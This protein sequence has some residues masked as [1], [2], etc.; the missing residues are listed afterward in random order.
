MKALSWRS[1]R[2]LPAFLLS[3]LLLQSQAL[4]AWAAPGAWSGNGPFG[5]TIYGM[6]ADPLSP[7]LFYLSTRS[8]VFRSADGGLSWSDASVGITRQLNGPIEHARTAAG[9]LLS[10]SSTALF[11]TNN[12]GL[13]WNDR[14]PPLPM[15][16]NL[17]SF[18]LSPAQPGRVYLMRSDGV[19]Q[20][21]DNYGLT[22]VTPGSLITGTLPG[23]IQAHPSDAAQAL[24]SARDST[25]GDTRLFRTT[26]GG[27]SWNEITCGGTCPWVTGSFSINTEIEYAG[28]S[29]TVY[30]IVDSLLFRSLD[31]GLNWSPLSA[32][33][34]EQ[35]RVNPSNSNEIYL[36]GGFG[37]AYSSDGGI[38][39]NE[40]LSNFSGSASE[41]GRSTVLSFNPFNPN[42][43]LAGS[44]TNGVYRRA[45]APAPGMMGSW[46][47]QNT[48]L[49][50]Q[51]IRALAIAP[52]GLRLHVGAADSVA[53][54]LPAFRS[55]D[56]GNSWAST[57]TGLDS[58]QFRALAI[59]PN[60]TDI[61]YAS[62]RKIPALG[63]SGGTSDGNGG[64]YK[65]I[66]A[67]LSWS[68]I[69]QGLPLTAST[70]LV[71]RLGTVRDIV[72]D[73]FSPLAGS[74]PLQ[75]LYIGASGRLRLDMGMVVT[76]A[77]RIY[78]STDAGAN[79]S[80]A[81]NG[82][83]GVEN[84]AGVDTYASVVQLLQ[85]PADTTGNT[86][87]AATF[88]G[89]CCDSAGPFPSLPNGVFR[90]TDGGM[91]WTLRSNGLPHIA[92]NPANSHQDVLSLALDPT[93]PSGNTLY[94][95]V[96]DSVSSFLGT[97]YKTTSGG[98][99]WSFAGTGLGL[100]D[101]RDLLVD[102]GN[103]DVYAAV[104][105]PLSN[106][107][108]GVFLSRDGG[109][110]WSAVGPGFP[111]QAVALKLALDRSG[112]NPILH[113]G[114]SRSLLSIEFLPDADTDGVSN[115]IEAEAPN[116]GDGNGDAI[117]DNQQ[118]QVASLPQQS[119][120]PG[121]QRRPQVASLAPAEGP[122]GGIGPY[123]TVAIE[124]VS[125]TCT[126]VERVESVPSTNNPAALPIEDSFA[127][128]NGVLRFRIPDCS[129]AAVTLIYHGSDFT[130]DSRIH[131]FASPAPAQAPRWQVLESANGSADRWQ[132][133][134]TDGAAGDA[135]VETDGVILFQG[136]PAVL[137]EVFFRDG[138]EVD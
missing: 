27:T 31:H 1:Y 123:V 109:A 61:V 14:S 63:I 95:S 136:G 9:T 100:R 128:P 79:W 55:T 70:P 54:N 50:A 72:L 82:L 6:T 86:L 37:I 102:P 85:S 10:L 111:P 64:V 56:G 42:Q 47:K 57:T 122:A 132:F 93:D 137:A 91:N 94:A 40:D 11:F 22:W 110:S 135:T 46:S 115:A 98:M 73:Q 24:A 58:Q 16:V 3:F 32:P 127:F 59:D 129:A 67:G 30:L 12:G 15:G 17:L 60:N 74:G 52:G 112:S 131:Y 107:D 121:N 71:S 118:A 78:K 39:W 83:G 90:T 87:Y 43:I 133:N 25:T 106:G 38:S 92:A 119:F 76:E 21:S 44:D 103:G 26:N 104:V 28:V 29:G 48:G 124:P 8:G 62:G 97:V 49:S 65:S 20:R 45:A 77:A 68:T 23:L 116:N 13:S 41:V 138:L 117:S 33:A 84:L 35:L 89:A 51:L 36:S 108:G 88:I 99:N 126:E 81:D 53:P 69:D 134:L 130:A 66:D 2:V 114:T 18:S 75:T 34:H 96:N 113:A 101:V 5:G 7:G 125:G 4:T 19:V 105:D 120:L 80:A